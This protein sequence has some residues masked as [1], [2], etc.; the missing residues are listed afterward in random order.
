MRNHVKALEHK[1]PRALGGTIYIKLCNARMRIE[2]ADD[3]DCVR[4]ALEILV[5]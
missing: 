3:A 5:Q 2:G 4:A 1:V